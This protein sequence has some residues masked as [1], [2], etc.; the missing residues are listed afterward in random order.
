MSFLAHFDEPH[1]DRFMAVSE[2]LRLDR[3]TYLLRRGEPGGDIFL[4]EDGALEVVDRR[5]TPEV[6]LAVL[7]AGA[8]VGEMAFLDDAPRSADV[9]AATETR[10]R[11]WAKEDLRALLARDPGLAAR[12]FESVARTAASRVR[13]LSTSAV[14]GGVQASSALGLAR[15]RSDVDE[16]AG[17]TKEALLDAETRLRQSPGAPVGT[18]SIVAA[19]ERLQAD[20]REL[21][22]SYAEEDMATEAA[23][24]LRRELHPY[25]VRSA[26][27]ERC[28]RRVQGVTGT[29]EVLAHV[30]VDT[31]SGDGQLGEVLDRWLLDRPTLAAFRQAREVLVDTL[32]A[33]LPRHRNRRALLLNAGTGSLVAAACTRA[34]D[35]PT[36]LTIVDQSREAL[37][38]L[39]A[40]IATRPRTVELQTVQENLVEVALGRARH[41]FPPQDVI[42]AHGLLEYMPDRIALSLLE[43]A[44]RMLA[45]EGHLVLTALTPSGD[46]VLLDRL[47]GWPTVRRS[48]ERIQRLLDRAG[49]DATWIPD[50]P[51]P[52]VVVQGRPAP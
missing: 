2:E 48:G 23:R 27:A 40:G 8:V 20:L 3:G 21:F 9:R 32:L 4:V 15:I 5:A 13:T 14:T 46:H 11:R 30:L 35:A 31:P 25:L 37:A 24:L 43:T 33:A 26:L 17:R 29:A 39:D 1:L 50:L 28:I 52:L 6:I 7:D 36:V 51:D 22:A 19:L 18:E 47:L 34:A 49:L 10:V 16:L 38:F 45:P 12:F 41:R 44:A 42:V